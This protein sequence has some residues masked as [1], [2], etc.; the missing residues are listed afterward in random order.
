MVDFKRLEDMWNRLVDN[1]EI[2]AEDEY[3]FL[4]LL[5]LV[6]GLVKYPKSCYRY[7]THMKNG[8]Q[9]ICLHFK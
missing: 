1:L 2:E 4:A 7:T 5:G 8:R 9:Y 6:K 3:Y